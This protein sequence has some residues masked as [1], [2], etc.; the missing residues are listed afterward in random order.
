[1]LL[2]EGVRV[3]GVSR[4]PDVFP[5]EPLYVPMACDLS[6]ISATQALFTQIFETYPE[7]RLVINNAGYGVLEDLGTMTAATIQQQYA[8]M[9]EAPTLIA[10]AAVAHFQTIQHGCLVNVSSLA[11]ELPL[12]LMSIYNACKAGLS[13]LSKS[14]MLDE[15][16]GRY[17]VIDFRPGD[18]NTS[19]A[20]RMAG[21]LHWNGSDLRAVMDH[22]HAVAPGVQ[23]AVVGLRTA[24]L[25]QRSGIVRVGDLFQSKIAP[26]G[27]LLPWRWLLRIIRYYYRH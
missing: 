18:F 10:S 23:I 17:T 22:H 2:A 20:D 3:V 4:E 26:L 24:L 19:F 7:L 13:G 5:N 8:V 21:E 12:P 27:V 14:L 15:I 16:E 11:V 6:D 9:L 1:M 25:K